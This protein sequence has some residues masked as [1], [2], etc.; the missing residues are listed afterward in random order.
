MNSFLTTLMLIPMEV[1]LILGFLGVI[2]SMR[3]VLTGKPPSGWGQT[4]FMAGSGIVGAIGMAAGMA[5]VIMGS[6][7]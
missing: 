4:W 1:G 7:T 5:H 2:P 3:P 6:A